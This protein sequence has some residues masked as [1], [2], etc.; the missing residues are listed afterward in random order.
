MRKFLIGMVVSGLAAGAVAAGPVD[1]V[2]SGLAAGV[3]VITP[4]SDCENGAGP[5]NRN[6]PKGGAGPNSGSQ[7]S[8]G[9]YYPPNSTKPHKKRI[10]YYVYYPHLQLPKVAE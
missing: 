7:N 4:P 10:V 6:V 9:Q 5:A 8:K 3:M 2:V 1:R